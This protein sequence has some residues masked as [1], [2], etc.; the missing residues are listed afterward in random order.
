MKNS[1][2]LL[3]QQ[4]QQQ[5]RPFLYPPL[6]IPATCFNLHAARRWGADPLVCFLLLT[7]LAVMMSVMVMNAYCCLVSV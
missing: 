3:Q 5:R 6:G 1:L 7:K 2:K 4:K